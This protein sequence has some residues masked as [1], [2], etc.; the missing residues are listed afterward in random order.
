MERQRPGIANTMLKMIKFGRLTLPHFK[1]YYKTTVDQ[2]SNGSG[3]RTHKQVNGTEIKSPEI[4]L[5][6]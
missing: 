3:K 6:P 5:P 1:T 4:D 2:D